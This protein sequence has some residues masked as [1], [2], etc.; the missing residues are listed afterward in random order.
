MRAH[1]RW[2]A[3]T[4]GVALTVSPMAGSAQIA[5][6]ADLR[7]FGEAQPVPRSEV[8][9]GPEITRLLHELSGTWSISEELA[10]DAASPKG[11]TGKGSIIWR[12]GPGGFSVV[13]EYR[14]QQGD[15]EIGGLGVFWWDEA[16]HGYHTIWCDSTNP[17]GCIEFKNVVRWEGSTLV[18][19][20]DYE[21]KGRKYTFKEVFGDIREDS[22]TQTLY[23]G[24]MGG[25]LKVDQ[26]IRG[27]RMKE[28]SRP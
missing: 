3:A 23:S 9:V 25:A 2:I 19:Q 15:D 18:L 11:K 22:F 10:P 7:V 8:K 28:S 6:K 1:F 17:G 21:V 24:D 12:P 26:I 27:K 20:E 16:A 5:G 14:S 13:E 4:L